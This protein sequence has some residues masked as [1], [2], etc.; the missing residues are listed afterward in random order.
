MFTALEMDRCQLQDTLVVGHLVNCE[1]KNREKSV[2]W[3]TWLWSR[4][5]CR[6]TDGTTNYLPITVSIDDVNDNTPE[7]INAP[8]RFNLDELTPPGKTLTAMFHKKQNN[9]NNQN[10]FSMLRSMNT[11][12][13]FAPTLSANQDGR[14][15]ESQS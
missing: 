2:S 13:I 5:A 9:K 3:H 10:K 11:I 8:Y 12:L 6:G 1:K 15:A 4:L 14:K 7:F